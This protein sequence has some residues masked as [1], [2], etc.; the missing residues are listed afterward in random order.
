MIS[1]LSFFLLMVIQLVQLVKCDNLF[2]GC[3]FE[4][5]NYEMIFTTPYKSVCYNMCKS[6]SYTYYTHKEQMGQCVCYLYP[7]PAAEYMPG[8]PDNCNGQL[9]YN[10]IK[11]NWNFQKCYKSPQSNMTEIPSDSFK[12]CM[13]GCAPQQI[14]IARPTGIFP[15]QTNCVCCGEHDLDGMEE[16]EC[17]LEKYYVFSHTPTPVPTAKRALRALA[18][19]Q[20][21]AFNPPGPY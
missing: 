9:Q 1:H 20:R 8:T 16:T 6:K 14:A 21:Q 15:G 3:G 11:S 4:V 5:V 2:I 7:P 17:D 10:L 12:A 13:D 19:A 18:I